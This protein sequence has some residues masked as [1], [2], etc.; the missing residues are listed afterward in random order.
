MENFQQGI[1]LG[2]KKKLR[3]KSDKSSKIIEGKQI[4]GLVISVFYTFLLSL[5]PQ[6][7]S[8]MSISHTFLD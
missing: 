7:S 2:L 1:E 6:T 4:E 3:V 5:F 8:R